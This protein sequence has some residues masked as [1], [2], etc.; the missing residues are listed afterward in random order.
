[1]SVDSCKFKQVV[2]PITA[3]IPDVGSLLG[4][5]DRAPG[6]WY[7]SVDLDKAFFSILMY[8][9]HHKQFAATWQSQQHTLTFLPQAFVHSPALCHNMVQTELGHFDS[10]HDVS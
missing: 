1:M 8:K 2:I 10:S 3:T 4:Q 5:I 7:T 6:T 9:G